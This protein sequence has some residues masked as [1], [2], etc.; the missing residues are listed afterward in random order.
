[1]HRGP[2]TATASETQGPNEPP[3]IT[4]ECPLDVL[5]AMA[6]TFERDAFGHDPRPKSA[7]LG[8][9]SLIHEL[10]VVEPGWRGVWD[11]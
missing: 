5:A 7:E 6:L 4:L 10:D 3:I 1:L 8:V 9:M 2:F 11:H